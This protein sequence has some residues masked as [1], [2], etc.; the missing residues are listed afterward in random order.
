MFAES[1]AF[2]CFILSYDAERVLFA[3]ATFL[4]LHKR[5]HQW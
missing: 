1:I 2:L 5:L 4:V 3:I